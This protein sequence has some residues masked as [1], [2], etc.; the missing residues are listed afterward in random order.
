MMR[1]A[2]SVPERGFYVLRGC[3]SRAD[4]DLLVE[5]VRD[6][7]ST[8]PFGQPTMRDGSPLS[9]RV[10]SWG[11]W[12]WWGDQL[13]IRY[14]NQHQKNKQAWP[15]LPAGWTRYPMAFLYLAAWDAQQRVKGWT[16]ASWNLPDGPATWLDQVDTGLVNYYAPDAVLGWHVDKTET[17]LRSPILTMSLGA[18]ARFEIKLDG[19]THSMILHSGDGCVMAGHSRNAE[20]RIVKLLTPAEVQA[21]QQADLFTGAPPADDIYNPITNGARLS[22]TW[23]RTGLPP[24]KAP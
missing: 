5:Q 9:V 12:G 2:Y 8:H 1:I 23:R 10:T 24:A 13:G 3:H 7:K 18:S 14:V 20:H 6:L 16:P 21:E 22:I 15:R 19:E 17:D 4:I 11:P